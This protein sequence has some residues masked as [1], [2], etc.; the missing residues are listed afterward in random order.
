M[1]I[2]ETLCEVVAAAFVEEGLDPALGVVR[3]SDRPDLAQFQCNGALAAAK[4]SGQ[5]PRALAE[6][7]AARLGE[8]RRF[9]SVDLAGPG[10]INLTLADT[11][12]AQEVADWRGEAALKAAGGDTP[13]KVVIDYGGPNVAKPLHVGHIR[14]AILGECL[15]R[16]LRA[17]GDEVVS[18]VHLGDW[19]LPMGQLITELKR[20]QPTLIYFDE[21]VDGPYPDEPPVCLED[22]ERLYPQ[23]SAACKADPARAAEA[24]EATAALQAGRPGYRA[25]WRW[26][27]TISRQAIEREYADLGVTF[28]LWKG[29]ADADPFIADMMAALREKGLTEIDDGAEIIR[30]DR[31]TDKKTTPPLILLK[32]DGSVLYGTTDLATIVDRV[33]S[34]DPDRILYVVDQ[35]QAL[36]F[37][38]VFRAAD[39][40]GIFPEARLEHIGFG[41]INGADGKPYKTRDGGVLKLRA[42]IDDAIAKAEERMAESG[43]GEGLSPQE[44]R[45]AAARI[46][47][48]AL[49]FAD[50]SNPRTSDYVFDLD[51][52]V[53]FEGK[54]GPYLL[55]AAK[56]ID[57]V[58]AKVSDDPGAIAISV[59][60]ERD[61]A[62]ALLRFDEAVTA[63]RA[64][65]MPHHLCEHA[66]ELA[67]A[68]SRFY[69]AARIADE[70]DPA[71]RR[72]R[73]T[74]ASVVRTQLA[75]IFNILGIKSPD[76]M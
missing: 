16:L 18:D 48:A 40:A 35:R 15:K 41:T 54:T 27:V 62:L 30:V 39:R 50:L 64:R 22:L 13:E 11:A 75:I 31:D 56:R 61:L 3:W 12:L 45:D 57:S 29:E 37:L 21:A 19:G 38:Q 66:F 58:L 10:F 59:S 60:E 20:E 76:R 42:L 55:Y 4:Q 17:T 71:L 36:H 53:A 9:Q 63:A 73:I 44:K 28:D 23:A 7:I 72:S 52:F 5:N 47:V 2:L 70:A 34:N 8:D 14:T 74:L 69:A 6:R 49:K 65:R 1:A 33:A 67:Q 43:V 25:L 68:F 24:R 26:F 46:A 51:R 32:R